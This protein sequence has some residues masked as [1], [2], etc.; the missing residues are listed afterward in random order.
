MKRIDP[1]LEGALRILSKVLNEEDIPFVLI[2]ALVPA[3]WIDL[4][5]PE[6]P[7][8]GSRETKDANSALSLRGC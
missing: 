8:L 3:I 4:K 7:D 6:P 2:G 5:R 1:E